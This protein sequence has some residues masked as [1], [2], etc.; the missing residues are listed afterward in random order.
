MYRIGKGI[1]ASIL[2]L[3]LA[4][5]ALA[6]TPNAPSGP[7]KV[8]VIAREVIKLGQRS[9]HEKFEAGWPKAFTA[10]NW[11][12]H[13]LAV[14]SMSGESRALYITGYDS[15]EAWE[16]DNQAQRKNAA[17]GQQLDALSL[18]DADFLK[19]SRTGVFSY[20]PDISYNANVEI[21][22]MRYFRIVDIQVKPGHNDHFVEVRKLVRAAHEKAGLKDHFAIYHL[23]G[24]GSPG[25]YLIML[26]MKSLAEDD[27]FDN[28]HGADYK[29]AL[30]QDG[31]KSLADFNMQGVESIDS[32]IFE[33]SQK[34]SYPSKAWIDSDPAYWTAKDDSAPQ[35]S[36]KSPA[37]K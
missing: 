23:N 3:C 37:K 21:G 12:V 4:G 35:T 31:Q 1:I 29:T 27:Q 26:P 14:S 34:M 13:Y 18:K 20:M 22:S 10:A 28:M 8:L 15:E 7:P 5:T 30:G 9:A 25:M 19:E 2:G 11:P 17:L 16:K 32:E 6:Q 33:F 36:A 24:G